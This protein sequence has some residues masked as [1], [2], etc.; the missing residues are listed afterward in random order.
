M[1]AE[2]RVSVIKEQSLAMEKAGTI[3]PQGLNLAGLANGLSACAA[4]LV[5]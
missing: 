1:F 3:T 4:Y 2:N 5:S